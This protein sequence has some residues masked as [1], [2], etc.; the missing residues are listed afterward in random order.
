MIG[1]RLLAAISARMGEIWPA[2]RDQFFGGRSVILIGDFFQLPPVAERA[3][4]SNATT[5]SDVELAGRNAYRAFKHTIELKEV[6]RQQGPE[7]AAFRDAL[8]GLRHNNP[9][10]EQWRLLSTRVQAN[11]TMEEVK[12][13][14]DALRIYPLNSMVNDYNLEHL[15]G[16]NKPC[17]QAVA[18]NT[19]P[20][21]DEV[22]AADAGNLHKKIPLVLGA[23]VMLTENIWTDAGLVNGA[24][25]TLQD[26]AWKTGADPKAEPPFVLLVKFDRYDGPECFPDREDLAG[27]GVVPILRSKRDFLKGNANCS[28]TQFPMTIAYAITVHKSQGATLVFAVL[29]ISQKD[30]Q[31]GLTYVAVSRVKTLEGIMFDSAFDLSALRVAANANHTARAEDIARR[32]PQHVTPEQIY[33][34]DAED[35]G[36]IYN[37]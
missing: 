34:R 24:I 15:E 9:T 28:R 13:F 37:A 10:A 23:R 33:G 22:E 26:I 11:L 3:L 18:D 7:Q 29:D 32:L 20:K 17:Y 4:Y 19:G 21:A 8:E 16:L 35:L 31:P 36:D 27:A 1:L 2:N 30:F 5:L 14:D 25:G 12:R 6:V